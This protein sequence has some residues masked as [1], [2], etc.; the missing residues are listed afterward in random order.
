MLFETF[1]D[2][3]AMLLWGGFLIALVLGAVV[4]KTNFCTMG[5]VSD[6]INIG[7]TAATVLLNDAGHFLNLSHQT[8]MCRHWASEILSS[9]RLYRAV[10]YKP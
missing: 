2:A 1:F 10:S 7:D 4:N 8:M 5:A 3:E 9:A 6:L